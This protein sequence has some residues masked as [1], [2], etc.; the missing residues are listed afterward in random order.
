MNGSYY[1]NSAFMGSNYERDTDS[2]QELPNL[3]ME[4][5]YI[6]RKSVV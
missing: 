4:Q 1:K 3:A 6:D 2:P 5:S